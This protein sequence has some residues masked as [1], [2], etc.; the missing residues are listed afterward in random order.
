MKRKQNNKVAG[1]PEE[2]VSLKERLAR[3][4]QEELYDALRKTRE[5]C[6]RDAAYLAR[7]DSPLDDMREGLEILEETRDCLVAAQEE[8]MERSR[9][10][11]GTSE[12]RAA[13]LVARCDEANRPMHEAAWRAAEEERRTYIE[14]GDARAATKP[15]KRVKPSR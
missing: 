13:Q 11:G 8:L 2:R 5:G 6:V 10:E 1:K 14:E 12:A 3:M 15:H 7:I 9:G 4:T